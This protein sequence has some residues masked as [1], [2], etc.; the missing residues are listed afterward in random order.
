MRYATLLDIVQ[1]T[2]G[3]T[4][5]EAERAI[6]AV[7]P[8]LAERITGGEADDI[9]AFLPHEVRPLLTPMHEPAAAFDLD[10]FHRRIAQR[11]GG[12]EQAA[13]EA[14]RAVFTA[15]GF[16]VA[17]GELRDMVAQ[18]PK[19]YA[20]LLNAAGIG[21][22]M[23]DDD[24]LVANVARRAGLDPDRARGATEAVLETL[25]ERISAGEVKDLEEE[26]PARLAPAL[27]RGLEH[28]RAAR[29]MGADE[30]VA[31]VAAREG[32]DPEA[33][34]DH[35]RA[36][37]AALRDYVTDEEFADLVAQLSKDYEPLLTP[38]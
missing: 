11:L 14:A 35:T 36:A 18:L 37:F 6:R 22:R 23:A 28:S 9:A 1:Q 38:A 17:P 24:D 4:R 8:V 31:T 3:V 26:L 30:F 29:R 25:G 13:H 15:L 5:P 21:R 12:D 7:L 16:A 34:R 32:V 19:D 27:E 2:A 33:A 10:E 20:P